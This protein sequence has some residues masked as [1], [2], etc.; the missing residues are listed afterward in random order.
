[1]SF[2]DKIF[3]T[4]KSIS[5]MTDELKAVYAYNLFINNNKSILYVTNTL[6][7]ANQVFQSL[8]CY[9][10]DVLLFPMD[11]FLTSEAIAISPELEMTR[12]ET[13][14]KLNNKKII[15]TNL[16]GYLRYLPSKKIFDNSFIYIEKNKDFNI[17][18]LTE[19][20]YNIG[21]KKETIVTTTGEMAVRGYVID[22]YPI[23]NEHPIRIEF[24]G[25]T[26]DSIRFFDTESQRTIKEI[27]PKIKAL[28]SSFFS[29]LHKIN[30]F[31]KFFFEN[32]QIFN[33]YRY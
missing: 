5:G 24:W 4:D 25:D 30:Y 22:I 26:V 13:L 27:I 21:Y 2:F 15:V 17:K 23:N 12:I 28:I 16:M 14:T 8:L 29:I 1:M 3:D 18:E 11:D 6:Y 9:T 7:Q 32:H 31:R 33:I 20:L 10:D 19:K